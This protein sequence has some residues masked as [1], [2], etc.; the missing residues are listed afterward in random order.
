MH[1]CR[2]VWDL[3]RSLGLYN[4][5]IAHSLLRSDERPL[6]RVQ[7]V[8]AWRWSQ[9]ASCHCAVFHCPVEVRRATASSPATS[10][11][12]AMVSAFRNLQL[13]HRACPVEVPRVTPSSSATSSCMARVS[14][15]ILPLHGSGVKLCRWQICCPRLLLTGSKKRKKRKRSPACCCLRREEASTPRHAREAS[16]LV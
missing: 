10:S 12:V 9:L 4:F 16:A 14:A 3:L 7:P 11:C 8:H 1:R 6:R 13:W 2:T 15:C 5:G